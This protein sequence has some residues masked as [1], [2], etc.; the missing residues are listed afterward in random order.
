MPRLLAITHS[1]FDPA[2]RFRVLQ[3]LP[4][5]SEAGWTVTHWSIRPS[6]Y[7]TPR[8]TSGLL[9]TAERRAANALLK[10]DSVQRFMRA[11]RFDVVLVSRE[12]PCFHNLLLRRNRRV[13]FDFDDAIHLG[14]S[15][16]TVEALCVAA[17]RVVVG[18]DTLA[19]AA[20]A[21]SSAVEVIPTAV[22]V[23]SYRPRRTFAAD[24]R[25]RV[26]WLGSPYSVRETLGPHLPLLA[27]LQRE[28]GFTFVIVSTRPETIPES[29][30]R[31]EFIPWTPQRETA[32]GDLFDIGIMPLVD[33]PLQRAKCG[34]KL[35]QYMAA[36]L[37]QVASP[38]GV[39]RTIVVAGETGFLADGAAEWRDA[40]TALI[41]DT[42][43]RGRMGAAARRRVAAEY[44]L[45]RWVPRWLPLLDAVARS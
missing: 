43:L 10:C 6:P 45:T 29:P 1:R 15:R 23:M 24:E 41:G 38:V 12:L 25:V 13:V 35:L 40:L 26:G 19:Q 7:R 11:G 3:Y 8:W 20:R 37:P 27:E 34:A 31:W 28:L 16:R 30:L 33:T 9:G 5:F 36:G 2:S 39:N 44:S 18:N 14:S 42:D 17:A 22:D 21:W 32:I 4:H